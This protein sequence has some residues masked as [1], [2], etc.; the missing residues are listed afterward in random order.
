[1]SKKSSSRFDEGW[2]LCFH[3][4]GRVT[5]GMDHGWGQSLPHGLKEFICDVFNSLAC[6]VNGHDHL[7]KLLWL[8]LDKDERFDPPKCTYCGA[9]LPI[10]GKYVTEDMLTKPHWKDV[11]PI[12]G[13]DKKAIDALV[14][15]GI[16][17]WTTEDF[18]SL[19]DLSP[20]SD[21]QNA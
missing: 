1:M 21:D 16:E 18:S 15:K 7:G 10:A 8:G 4:D 12:P 5:W 3:W 9:E 17:P 20:S 6:M 19:E 13:V 11:P 2:G 14:A